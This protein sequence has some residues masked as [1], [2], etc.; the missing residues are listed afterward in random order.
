MR[1]A[2]S[3]SI[4]ALCA[5]ALA[6]VILSC[7]TYDFEPVQPLAISQK[8]DTKIV[9]SRKA[10]PNMMLVV[11]KSG[12]MLLEGGGGPGT[13]R[14]GEMKSA[15]GTFLSQFGTTARLGLAMFPTST[16]GASCDVA[17]TP[18]KVF[19][20]ITQSNDVGTEL[21]AQATK[22]NTKIQAINNAGA[23]PA[24]GGTPTAATLIAVGNDPGLNDAKRDD[25][26]LLLT[27]GLP[28]CNNSL[29]G[30]TCTCL[31]ATCTSQK[32]S[33]LDQVQVV[34]SVSAL[35]Q[36]GIL[37]IVV[38]FGPETGAGNGRA[39]LNA[40]AEAGGFPRQCTADA[41][42]GAG[43]KCDP[44][45]DPRLCER[46]FYQAANAAELA[47][48][49]SRI[50]VRLPGVDPCVFDLDSKP[51]SPDLLAVYVG[52]NGET[53]TKVEPGANTWEF[54]DNGQTGSVKFK[55]DICTSLNNASETSPVS[56]E[57]RLVEA[58]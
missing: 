24:I 30:N 2:F 28:N 43:D 48:E 38:G 19:E 49:L 26:V 3:I 45:G 11:D 40:M 14:L 46:R 47:A 9:I 36:K 8:T 39:I 20:S 6:G 10:K 44:A 52:Q 12:S 25:F 27:D 23:E 13:T 15:M 57:I 16:S 35:K 56:V 50:G 22:I 54:V 7:Q 29:D 1:T 42:C 41:D 32:C 51:S 31:S 34:Q 58:L 5:S 33:C 18:G 17:C 37:T 55:G 21:Q 53:P 4:P